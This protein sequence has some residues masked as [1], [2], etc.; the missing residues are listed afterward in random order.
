VRHGLSTLAL[1][2]ATAALVLVLVQ[3]CLYSPELRSTQLRQTEMLSNIMVKDLAAIKADALDTNDQL[4]LLAGQMPALLHL[5]QL[6]LNATLALLDF[7]TP[8]NE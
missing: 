8:N 1:L 4:T 7:F 2:Y 6:E 3:V 5:N